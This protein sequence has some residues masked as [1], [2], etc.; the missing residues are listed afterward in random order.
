ML[1]S[2]GE[3]HTFGYKLPF[4]CS[5]KKTKYEALVVG[6]KT[7]KRVGIKKL[8]VFGDS[9]LVIKQVGGNYGVKSP[10]LATYR[11]IVQDLMKHCTFVVCK[12]INRNENKLVDSLTSL[13]K[14]RLSP[15]EDWRK[16]LLKAMV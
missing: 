4:P 13:I 8:K 12:M 9:E 16:P 10:S 14:G 5:N 7:A 11:A 15:L 1:K 3:E 2:L 6:L